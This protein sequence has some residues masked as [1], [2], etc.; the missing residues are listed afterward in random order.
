MSA[1]SSIGDAGTVT[2]DQRA[3]WNDVGEINDLIVSDAGEVRAALLDIG[4]FLGMGEKTIAVEMSDLHILN[5]PDLPGD[6]F[7]AMQGTK[8]ELENAPKFERQDAAMNAADASDGTAAPAAGTNMAS[9][10][11]KPAAEATVPA[12]TM[13]SDT[14]PAA[15]APADT[16]ASDTTEPAADAVAPA[17]TMAS[18]TTGTAPMATHEGYTALP[19]ADLTAERVDGATVYGPDDKSIGEVGELILGDDGKITDAVVDV[20][21]FLGI[22][23]RPVKIAYDEMQ[24]VQDDAGAVRVYVN[25]TKDTL[26]ERPEYES[27]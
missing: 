6:W 11:T 1:S 12:D 19:T 14:K 3:D 23:E 17:N 25:A 22:G 20:G 4:G 13:A 2:V 15:D 18:D 9:D 27:N 16:M 21:G 5:D 10:A 7:V 24:I 8:D 26:K